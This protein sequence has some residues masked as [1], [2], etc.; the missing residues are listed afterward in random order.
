MTSG[1]PWSV[2]RP[3]QFPLAGLVLAGAANVGGVERGGDH[4]VVQVGGA[5]HES[6]A[7]PAVERVQPFLLL[8]RDAASG[9]FEFGKDELA[10]A[11]V[12]QGQV[13]KARLGTARIVGVVAEPPPE[14]GDLPHRL[15]ELLLG[16]NGTSGG[17]TGLTRPLR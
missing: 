8:R 6:G 2:E 1:F 10:G 15:Q 16:Q 3:G 12:E 7:L 5:P 11:L 17:S 13:R 4:A 9:R 14:A